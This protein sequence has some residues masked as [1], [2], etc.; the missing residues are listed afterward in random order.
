MVEIVFERDLHPDFLEL[1]FGWI[2][3]FCARYKKEKSSYTKVFLSYVFKRIIFRVKF[4][5]RRSGLDWDTKLIAHST[6]H[7]WTFDAKFLYFK[8]IGCFQQVDFSH[9]WARVFV[10]RSCYC[11]ASALLTLHLSSIFY[12]LQGVGVGMYIFRNLTSHAHISFRSR[13]LDVSSKIVD[14]M[15]QQRQRRKVTKILFTSIYSG[16][17]ITCQKLTG[18]RDLW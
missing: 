11:F 17:T 2:V 13:L 16:D 15:H 1:F 4:P 18:R 6:I 12:I 9:W 7:F 10:Q 14:F 3:R 8:V 5:F